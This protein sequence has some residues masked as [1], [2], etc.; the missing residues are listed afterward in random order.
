MR[1]R[2]TKELPYIQRS[3]TA[4]DTVGVVG[5]MPQPTDQ[6]PQ[7]V[8]SS[9]SD[10]RERSKRG[11]LLRNIFM[12]DAVP[13]GSATNPPLPPA[14]PQSRFSI[15]RGITK[16][17]KRKW[18]PMVPNPAAENNDASPVPRKVRHINQPP[19]KPA[20]PAKPVFGPFAEETQRHTKADSPAESYDMA[21]APARAPTVAPTYTPASRVA[22]GGSGVKSVSQFPQG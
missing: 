6:A 22:K 18:E 20:L 10:K 1:S 7:I 14:T 19:A 17:P 4:S 8:P 3:S 11:E 5:I 12:R 13:S 9:S 21:D 2:H 15:F 16:N